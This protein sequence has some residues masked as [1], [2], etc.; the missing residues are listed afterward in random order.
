MA[1]LRARLLVGLAA[2]L[3]AVI[4][5]FSGALYA[6]ST[7]AAREAELARLG[8]L[9]DR[10]VTAV[11]WEKG[12]VKV[13]RDLLE[14]LVGSDTFGFRIQDAQGRPVQQYFPAAAPGSLLDGLSLQVPLKGLIV[15]YHDSGERAWI[16]TVVSRRARLEEDE[17]GPAP[18]LHLLLTMD[19]T[20]DH[21]ALARLVTTLWL[22]G[23]AVFLLG[24]GGAWVAV[25]RGLRPLRAMGD[26]TG[27]IDERTLSARVPVPPTGDELARLGES[28][29]AAL[30]R[31]EQS[32]V[33]ERSFIADASHELRTPVS[34]L[35]TT[36][37]VTLARPRAA[38]EYRAELESLLQTTRRMRGIVD[39]LLTL[40]RADA[41][42]LPLQREPVDVA[43]LLRQSTDQLAPIAAPRRVAL[44]VR[45]DGPVRVT[46]DPGLLRQLFDN[47][48]ANAI[49]YNR[50]GGRVDVAAQ[51]GAAGVVVSV[52]DNGIG[53]AAEHLP[54]LFERFYRVDTGRS[55]EEGGAGLGLPI[56]K[57]IAEA[58]G[59]SIAVES[60]PEKGSTFRVSLP[61]APMQ[62]A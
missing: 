10:L 50:E 46:G 41:G 19:V 37:E 54:H 27:R 12:S 44:E 40:A 20:D 21:A 5:G 13:E 36:L 11:S 42:R 9:A 6:A 4:F 49:R 2:V 23:P 43:G 14:G 30:E 33:R 39:S 15:L 60:E 47:L 52:R 29:N 53:I 38:E 25:G 45:T 8:A 56:A 17:E 31:L 1:S 32:F 26:A 34:I 28:L 22:L 51:N 57:W 3:G 58:H 18:D 55:R 62:G 35:L 16:G 24:I 61:A 59:G 7:R 48:I